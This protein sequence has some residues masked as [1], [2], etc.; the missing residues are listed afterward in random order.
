MSRFC[1]NLKFNRLLFIDILL[2]F[3]FPS[4][5]LSNSSLFL[6]SGGFFSFYPLISL[7]FISSF[8]PF[9]FS[10]NVTRVNLQVF[11]VI[12][13]SGLIHSSCQF[14]YVFFFPPLLNGFLWFMRIF[15]PD[16]A[17][18]HR[19]DDD[20][21]DQYGLLHQTRIYLFRVWLLSHFFLILFLFK[22]VFLYLIYLIKSMR[23]RLRG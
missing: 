12:V 22:N 4:L 3:Y 17:P 5:F 16:V 6:P 19:D 7:S 14:I 18:K 9:F 15:T 11:F 23:L 2:T 20:D 1:S 10:G 13:F 21:D 8:L